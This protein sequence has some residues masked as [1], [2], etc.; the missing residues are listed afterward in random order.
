[1]AALLHIVR[2]RTGTNEAAQI[3]VRLT[4]VSVLFLITF[5][6]TLAEEFA[7]AALQKGEPVRE[8]AVVGRVVSQEGKPVS[9]ARVTLL[10]PSGVDREYVTVTSLR[11]RPDG[12]FRARLPKPG[13]EGTT[14][15]ELLIEAEGFGISAASVGTSGDE[16]VQADVELSPIRMKAEAP[17]TV[18]F[19]G[20]DGK[21][22]PDLRVVPRT[23]TGRGTPAF[24]TTAAPVSVGG[25]VRERLASR[26]D[27]GGTCI[28]RGL[29]QQSV[30]QL[31]IDDN[32]FARLTWDDRVL[33]GPGATRV[34][35]PV[36]L[37]AAASV[38]GR[39]RYG[40][41]GEPAA[42]VP[43]TAQALSRPGNHGWGKTVTNERG[44][45]ELK[46]LP[47]GSFNVCVM[48]G[49][50]VEKQWTASAVEVTVAEGERREHQDLTLIKG[51]LIEGKVVRKESGA[52]APGVY[53][54][55]HGPS[56]PRSGAMIG[57][58]T[59]GED[60]SFSFR[61]PPGENFM[62]VSG[63]APEGYLRPE[64]GSPS[65]MLELRVAD[66]QTVPVTLELPRDPSPLVSGRVLD[67]DGKPV[68][69]AFVSAESPRERWEYRGTRTDAA[70]QFQLAA[71]RGSKLR[72]GKGAMRTAE[73]VETRG[74]EE[75]LVL[76]V[77]AVADAS[78]VVIVTAGGKPVKGARVNVGVKWG[79]GSSISSDAAI[80]DE[81]GRCVLEGLSADGQYNVEVEAGGHDKRYP[82]LK[83]TPGRRTE[84]EVVFDKAQ[85]DN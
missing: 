50:D 65:R 9:D 12:S 33:V 70:G 73:A 10:F 38:V 41:T 80:T 39:V 2:H 44:E 81:H 11:S 75:D 57:G 47:R 31:D 64:V 29:P 68:A 28:L 15:Y 58:R 3:G 21:P 4:L 13:G 51:G 35:R 79:D 83:L 72:A 52:G 16:A 37:T 1:M 45:Y 42:G 67:A 7:P 36:R 40:G 17:L 71:P 14:R 55:L 34:E 76:R 63:P 59:T 25:E 24:S 5:R 23:I 6:A 66:G 8:P 30:V 22:V 27:A 20:S 48:L 18:T 32:R 54:G 85:R 56:R 43:V 69:G 74:A 77:Q 78:A 82:E 49:P 19:V 61:V 26:T 46:Q 53:V 60:G 62:Y 84:L